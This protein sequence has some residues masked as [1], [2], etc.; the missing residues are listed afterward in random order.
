M[1]DV[2]KLEAIYGECRE[3]GRVLAATCVSDKKDRAKFV[4]QMIRDD[5]KIRTTEPG[6]SVQL[7]WG[8]G[9]GCSLDPNPKK[10]AKATTRSLFAE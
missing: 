10:K 5:L 9:D 3:C 1:I 6:A 2:S 7:G 4:A 8:H